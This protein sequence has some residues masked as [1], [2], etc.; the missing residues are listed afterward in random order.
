M[1]GITPTTGLISGID[2]A[3]IIDQLI[4]I[5]SRPKIFAINRQI[6]LKNEQA[7]FLGLNSSILSLKSAAQALS[8]NK[9]WRIKTATSSNPSVLAASASTTA[10]PGTY[11]FTVSRLVANNQQLSEGFSDS[12]ASSVG[13][14]SM[15]FEFGAG[16]LSR[17]MT[18]AELNGGEGVARGKIKI[19]DSAGNTAIVDLSTAVTIDDVVS[20][21]NDNG[22]AN[23][24]ASIAGDRLTVTDDAGAT[25][26]ITDIAGYSTATSLGIAK[27]SNGLGVLSGDQINRV[28]T[29]TTLAVFNDGNGVR[30]KGNT[31]NNNGDIRITAKD[32]TVFDLKLEGVTTV[33]KLIDAVDEQTAGKIAIGVSTSGTGLTVTDNSGGSGSLTIEATVTNTTAAGALGIAGTTTGAQLTGQRTIATINSTLAGSIN[34]GLGVGSGAVSITDRAGN[35]HSFTVTDSSSIADILE[36][37]SSAT[38]GAVTAA[39]KSNGNGLVLTDNTGSSTSNFIVSGE[40]AE[41]LGIATDVAGVASATV[42]GANAQRQYV[43]DATLLSDLNYGKGIGKGSFRITD[44]SGA[45]AVVDISG[46]ETTL[47]D[48]IQEINSRG[49]DIAASIN[50]TGDGIVIESTVAGSV[51][52]KVESVTGTTAKDLNIL[53]EAADTV[54]NIINGTYERTV[55]FDATDTLQE[56]AD[57]INGAGLQVGAAILNDGVGS[58]PF[59]LSLSSKISGLT[60]DMSLESE[61]F[62]FGFTTLTEARNAAVFYGSSD[63][64]R[65]ILLT[66]DTNTL[67]SAISGVSVTLSGT[68]SSPVELTIAANVDE[69]VKQVNAVLT[70]FNSV[71]DKIN[72]LDFYDAEKEQ[73]GI[74]LGDSTLSRVRQQLYRTVQDD[75]EGVDTQYTRLAQVGVSIGEGGKLKLDEE[76]LRE[77][78]ADDPEAVENVFSAKKLMESQDEPLIDEDGNDTGVTIPSDETKYEDLGVFEMLGRLAEDLTN[79]VDGTLTITNRNYDDLIAIQDSR[80]AA[81][82]KS[83][84][85]K[86]FRYETQFAQM[87]QA[88]ASLQAQQSSLSQIALIG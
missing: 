53:G 63:P 16:K 43:T 7:A 71:I 75:A 61:G 31:A 1:S 77:A 41:A 13:A 80:I 4:A 19:T 38:G 87:E 82:D 23:V 8:S 68:S 9:T 40:G 50:E 49:L 55:T 37:I 76:R 11:Q 2:T 74:L 60:G 83:L 6:E 45:Q 86:R 48:V 52:L 57:K 79:S 5:D 64:A 88:L 44:S 59:R 14:T 18:L 62:D 81:F 54:D 84:E 15:T 78:F 30:F 51:K 46:T 10:V 42:N 56:I 28:T 3:N 20:A 27:T 32:G 70:A 73:K 85:A 67:D 65:A 33:Q 22:S 25:F 12:T 69:M 36:Q 47:G 34:G 58:A 26:S 39:I 66:S 24:T 21:I 29:N 72:S 17:D 35:V